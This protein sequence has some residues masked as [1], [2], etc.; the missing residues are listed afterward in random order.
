MCTIFSLGLRGLCFTNLCRLYCRSLFVHLCDLP[1]PI[2]A[3]H[4]A[5]LVSTIKPEHAFVFMLG[6][7]T[8]GYNICQ[9]FSGS[10]WTVLVFWG[11]CLMNRGRIEVNVPWIQKCSSWLFCILVS[12]ARAKAQTKLAQLHVCYFP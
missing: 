11:H 5:H 4:L 8:S 9:Y 12:A 3:Y 1:Y 10:T 6:Y 7:G 2:T